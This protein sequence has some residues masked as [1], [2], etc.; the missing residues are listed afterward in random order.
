MLMEKYP[1][2]IQ[3]TYSNIKKKIYP[4]NVC[5]HC[6][7]GQGWYYIYKDINKAIQNKEKIQLFNK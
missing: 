4:M 7:S 5:S 3:N 6:G 2:R 1:E